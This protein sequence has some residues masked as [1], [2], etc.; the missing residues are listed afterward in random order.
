ML[1]LHIHLRERF[2]HVLYMLAGHL[3][4]VVAMPHQR[5]YR[6]HFA[7]RTERHVQ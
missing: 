5:T 2:L 7:I 1:E 3:H 4:Q 6:A